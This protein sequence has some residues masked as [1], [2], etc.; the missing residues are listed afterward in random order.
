MSIMPGNRGVGGI[1]P[2]RK[3]ALI[4]V[5]VLALVEV[6]ILYGGARWLHR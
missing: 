1:G 2:V 6:F 3:W 5:V 4:I